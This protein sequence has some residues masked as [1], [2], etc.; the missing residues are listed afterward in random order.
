[1]S[2]WA[3]QQK[4]T[5]GLWRTTSG[6]NS[7]KP[8][9]YESDRIKCLET[10]NHARCVYFVKREREREREAGREAERNRELAQMSRDAKLYYTVCPPR[11][12]GPQPQQKFSTVTLRPFYMIN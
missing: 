3:I 9:L 10:L 6:R 8:A 5:R 2:G 7:Q 12:R 11:F 4:Y 1:M